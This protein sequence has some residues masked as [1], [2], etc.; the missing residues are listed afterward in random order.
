VGDDEL[1]DDEDEDDDDEDED[2]EDIERDDE[3]DTCCA[4]GR[5]TPLLIILFLELGKFVV[6]FWVRN[7]KFNYC[8]V[9][10]RHSFL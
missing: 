5:L 7:G 4:E 2:V 1:D 8:I 10:A 3:R 6:S 9:L